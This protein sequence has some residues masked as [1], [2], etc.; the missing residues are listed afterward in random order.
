[1]GEIKPIE[2]RIEILKLLQGKKMRTGELAEILGVDERTI[3]TDVD[4]LREGMKLFGVEFKIESKHEG[5]QKH[6]YK[7]TVHPI[8]LG[9]NL[10]ELFALLKLLEKES[11]NY[12]GDVYE[13]IFQS[14]YSQISNYAEGTISPKLEGEH[15][16]TSIINLLEE[17]AFNQ[18]KDYKLV[19]WEKSGNFIEISYPDLDDGQIREEVRLIGIKGDKIRV[20]KKNGEKEWINYNELLIDWSEVDYK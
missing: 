9:L 11:K 18:S 16:K 8:V 13:N 20:E 2:R 17:K 5:S 14:I 4:S 1:M 10:S 12:G 7:S 19:Y 15:D 3:R 6:Y